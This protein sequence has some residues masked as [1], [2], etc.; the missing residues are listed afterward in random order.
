MRGA[1]VADVGWLGR[2]LVRKVNRVLTHGMHAWRW[3]RMA[4]STEPGDSVHVL[5]SQG[6]QFHAVLLL[7]VGHAPINPDEGKNAVEAFCRNGALEERLA[8]QSFHEGFAKPEAIHGSAFSAGEVR[9][10]EYEA[11]SLDG[12][13]AQ[14][15]F[16]SDL[17]P[18]SVDVI[19]EKHSATIEADGVSIHHVTAK[20]VVLTKAVTITTGKEDGPIGSALPDSGSSDFLQ[21]S[22][23][24]HCFGENEICMKFVRIVHVSELLCVSGMGR[25]RTDLILL[26]KLSLGLIE[27]TSVCLGSKTNQDSMLPDRIF[28]KMDIFVKVHPVS[29]CQADRLRNFY[30]V[31]PVKHD[32]RHRWLLRNVSQGKLWY[33]E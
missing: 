28:V 7:D 24:D 6:I 18:Y 23:L 13:C 4:I 25:E 3:N 31:H 21:E 22:R 33:T 30:G 16:E 27:A 1:L 15:L 10:I 2:W 11:E 17:L 9:E 19:A 32:A 26:R 14:D 29:F 12:E 8:F 20:R 5:Q